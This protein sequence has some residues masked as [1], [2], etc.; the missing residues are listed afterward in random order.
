MQFFN[1]IEKFKFS[2]IGVL[3]LYVSV[4]VWSNWLIVKT[5]V[6]QEIKDETIAVLDFSKDPVVEEEIP[7]NPENPINP[8]NT[9]LEN[10]SA[11]IEKEKTT[12]TNSFSKSQA[13]KEVWDEL[14]AMEAAEFNSLKGDNPKEIEKSKPD[15]N[16]NPNLVK[17]GAS[18]NDKAG[19]G[20]DVQAIVT[21]YVKDRNVLSDKKPSYLCKSEGIVRVNIKVNQKGQ[22][23][24]K[25]I[26]E[27][28][29]NTQNECLRNAALEYAGLWKF[30]Q[31]FN[32]E[33]RKQGWIEFKYQAQ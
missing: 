28:K 3:I 21:Y 25:S 2:I 4:F 8:N 11:N 19:Y 7:E 1:F 6:P 23:V 17:E 13:E 29:T 10:V 9:N 30:N 26:D 27:S 33:L 32:D 15:D 12:Y 16:S 18:K 24:S 14:K 31:N 22:V 5:N 20:M